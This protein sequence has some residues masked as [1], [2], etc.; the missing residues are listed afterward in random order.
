MVSGVSSS[1]LYNSLSN[2]TTTFVTKSSKGSSYDD[3]VDEYI[4]SESKE[5]VSGE[6]SLYSTETSAMA[7]Y[8]DSLSSSDDSSKS[9][10]DVASGIGDLK[11]LSTCPHCGAMFM[12]GGA[13]SVC[14]KC[15]GDMNSQNNA[16]ST[17]T[18]TDSNNTSS[19]DSSNG[20]SSMG[21][22]STG[23]STGD[24]GQIIPTTLS[25]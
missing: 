13:M 10:S 18:S 2:S 17:K 12:G 7:T 14:P 1:N 3:I 20:S 6:N 15:G 21:S 23:T 24:I 4:P 5:S 8:S 22:S 16:D 11:K 25:I 19:I 9:L